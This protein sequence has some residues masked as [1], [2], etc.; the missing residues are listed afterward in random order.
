[1]RLRRTSSLWPS[2][3]VGHRLTPESVTYPGSQSHPI[4]LGA[5][6]PKGLVPLPP[7]AE[8]LLSI[9][10]DPWV[11]DSPLA[12]SLVLG[13]FDD[14][15]QHRRMPPKL[16]GSGPDRRSVTDQIES[17][18]NASCGFGID[19][20]AASAAP[21]IAVG[22]LASLRPRPRLPLRLAL[23]PGSH[24]GDD[25]PPVVSRYRMADAVQEHRGR[26]G[27]IGSVR[28]IGVEH[29]HPRMREC[30]ESIVC[31]VFV[32][33][34]ACPLLHQQ[35]ARSMLQ[36]ERQSLRETGTLSHRQRAGSILEHVGH[37]RESVLGGVA[38]ACAPLTVRTG[39]SLLLR[40][41]DPAIDHASRGIEVRQR[42]HA[43]ESIP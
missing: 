42:V 41:G 11:H 9:V 4:V 2:S 24:A 1:M 20:D 26:I 13:P 23:P 21:A 15:R 43:M 32:T 8:G 29:S 35:D 28:A 6:L 38:L 34:Q 39:G 31:R 27:R 37:D 25:H 5:G 17:T 30:P 12:H 10:P 36:A 33:S 3:M 14:P 7:S 18:P 40:R 16:N 19:L 22:K